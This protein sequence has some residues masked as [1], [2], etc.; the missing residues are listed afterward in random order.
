MVIMLRVCMHK[1]VSL[2]CVCTQC[3]SQQCNRSWYLEDQINFGIEQ[4]FSY[5]DLMCMLSDTSAFMH[6]LHD[7]M[8]L[9][10]GIAVIAPF[11]A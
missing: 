2:S 1:F 5:L 9:H 10:R 7:F 11:G 6:L 8:H 4:H 3:E